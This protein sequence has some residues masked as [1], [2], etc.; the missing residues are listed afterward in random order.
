MTAT[1]WCKTPSGARSL[2][3]FLIT[4]L[5]T[6]PTFSQTP[7]FPVLPYDFALFPSSSYAYADFNG[8]GQVDQAAPNG[9]NAIGISFNNGAN[10]SPT[11]GTIQLACQPQFVVAADLNNDSK[12]D[13]AFS[14]QTPN[15]PAYVGVVLGNGDGT[16]QAASYYAV[17]G[18]ASVPQLITVDLNGD[19]YL[20]VA[21]L[22]GSSQVG[23]LLNQGSSK[24]GSLLTASLYAAPTGVSFL[25]IGA[26]DFNGDGKQDIVAGNTQIAVYYGKGDGTLNTPQLTT[27]T[28][29]GSQPFVTGDFNR[30]G[31]ADIAFLGSPAQSP[32][33]SLQIL[34]GDPS[35]KFTTGINLALDP[36]VNYTTIVPFQNTIT[37]NVTNFALIG[38][39]TSIALNDGNGNLSLGESYGVST[40]A[41][42]Q[43]GSNGN[44]NLYFQSNVE[45]VALIGNGNGTFQGPPATV[46]GGGSSTTLGL[47]LNAD[48]VA[49]AL[50]IDTAGNLVAA[51]GRGNGRFSVTSR[52][53]G[54]GQLLVTGDFNG[55]GKLDALT[56]IPG[57]VNNQGGEIL[58]TASLYFYAGNGDGTF[59]PNTTPVNLTIS[60]AGTPLVGDFNGDNKLDL[61]LPYG[62]NVVE[63]PQPPNG[64]FFFAGNGDGTFAAPVSLPLPYNTIGFAVDLNNDHKLDII[65]GGTVSLGNGDGTFTQQPLGITGTILAMGD[66]NGDGKLDLVVG[67]NNDLGL[68][69]GNGDGTFQTTPFYTPQF[70]TSYSSASGIAQV[71]IG[72]VN[73]DGHPD[74]LVQYGFFPTPGFEF[75]VFTGDGTGNFANNLTVSLPSRLSA[76]T[77]IS[78]FAR[79]NNQAPVGSS[80]HTL[81]YLFGTGGAVVSLVNQL[82]PAPSAPVALSSKT[83]LAASANSAA[84]GQQLTLT[85]TV[86]GGTPTGTVSFVAG[87]KT[88][89]TA[90]LTNGTA[91]LAVSFPAA[92]SFAVI[93]NYSGD[94][95]NTP[96]SSNP[97]SLAIAPVASKT[98]LTISSAS[99]GTNQQLTFTAT[100]SG[101]NPTGTVT[102]ASATAT[103][104]TASL[105]N[106]VAT[107]PFTFTTAGSYAVTASYA[108]DLDNS[109]STSA[110]VTV[111]IATPDYSITASPS[112]ATISPG[113]SATTTLTVTPVG[114]YSGTVKF[115]CGTLPSGA[116]CT[117]APA[118]VTPTSG[119][120][121]SVLTITTTAPSTARLRDR[122]I[123]LQ[124]IA[125][126]SILL[127]TLSPRKL[128]RLNRRF[129]RATLLTL[130]LAA[131]LISFSGC[132]SSS[133]SNNTPTNPGTPAGAQTITLT[134]ADSSGSLSHAINFQV[135]VQ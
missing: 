62:T 22:T 133:P 66:L 126:A 100:V 79:V 128:R 33:T 111:A 16:F 39:V 38:N 106:G 20:D 104:G 89:G 67:N 50:S 130:L 127:L 29:S 86:T 75:A 103:L 64:V 19:G 85:A 58:S 87:G 11:F 14:C 13:L 6:V 56:I 27:A 96:S 123:P 125:W 2:L 70:S 23:V 97:L 98:T 94:S 37:S 5:L 116:T 114:G 42:A 118:S 34:L 28:I 26:G 105:T 132:S 88:L 65:G 135:T 59:Q 17:P 25:Y 95:N 120:A 12:S 60:A 54:T 46:L 90:P 72:D 1:P 124:G 108:G 84:P 110:A 93:A 82:N 30:D 24:P 68:Y 121:T 92:G 21:V 32:A 49:D 109:S 122:S 102:F 119:A 57:N 61:I 115:S 69:A 81:D 15:Q 77:G 43:A 117:F 3:A 45:S 7:I 47:D 51:L 48:G 35:G 40:F 78:T 44:T 74:L 101:L 129:A 112:S 53:P 18:A 71:S 55:D 80:D 131:G 8:D 73:A 41:I 76:A 99:A 113:Q 36:S 52:T 107:L 9:I 10:H 83:V 134:A 4:L 63:G 31:L 91:T